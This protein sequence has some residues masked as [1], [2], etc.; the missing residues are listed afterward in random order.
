ML[1]AVGSKIG[2]LDA[3]IIELQ[4]RAAL[5]AVS[6]LLGHEVNNILTPVLAYVRLARRPGAGPE[7]VERA[8]DEAESGIRRT[9][10]IAAAILAL[11]KS[12][13]P[14]PSQRARVRD[15]AR[16]ATATLVRDLAKEGITCTMRVPDDLEAAIAATSLQQILVN[17]LQ[18]ARTAILGSPIGSSLG[19]QIEIDGSTWNNEPGVPYA[20]I[21]VADSGPGIEP[22]QREMLFKPF[23][24]GG[25]TTPGTGLGLT[26]CRELIESADGTIRVEANDPNTG[27]GAR[28]IITLPLAAEATTASD[29]TGRAA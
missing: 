21:D 26:V 3:E 25:S 1:D 16:Q 28:F 23:E 4:K 6:G 10:E 2:A 5:G 18:N 11:C 29:T 14:D 20:R 24:R 7:A 13:S 12:G 19:G 8:L 9:T 15:V 22:A 17:L 27:R